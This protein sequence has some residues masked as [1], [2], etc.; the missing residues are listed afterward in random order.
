MTKLVGLLQRGYSVAPV[1]RTKM[2]FGQ[3]GYVR[4]GKCVKQQSR[5]TALTFSWSTMVFVSPS[6]ASPERRKTRHGFPSSRATPSGTRAIRKN[7]SSSTRAR[8]SVLK[9][10]TGGEHVC[11]EEV[12]HPNPNLGTFTAIRR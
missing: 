2:E 4:T 7:L 11:T 1:F 8:S 6:V 9:T 3:N 12:P 10:Y 5:A